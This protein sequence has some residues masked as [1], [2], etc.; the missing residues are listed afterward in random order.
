[1]VQEDMTSREKIESLHGCLRYVA[2][3]EP[4]GI[5]FLTPLLNLAAGCPEEDR[6][7]NNI[8]TPQSVRR[9]LC[10]CDRILVINKGISLDY[11]LKDLPR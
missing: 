9:L 5:P 3:V 6:V 10:V 1:M 11:L 7:I 8:P 2:D 4:Y